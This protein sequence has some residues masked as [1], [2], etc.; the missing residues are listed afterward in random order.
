MK[1]VERVEAVIPELIPTQEY[2]EAL[3]MQV[4]I[5]GLCE[6]IARQLQTVKTAWESAFSFSGT[7]GYIRTAAYFEKKLSDCLLV[8][9]LNLGKLK[10]AFYDVAAPIAAAVIPWLNTAV[11]ALTDFLSVVSQVVRALTGG[12]FYT[13]SFAESSKNAQTAQKGMAKAVT[14]TGKSIRR[15]LAGFDEL[16]RLN[17]GSGGSGASFVPEELPRQTQSLGQS[18]QWLAEKLRWLVSLLAAID[19]TPA[20][21]AFQKL[22]A[23]VEPLT[24]EL[25]AGLEWAYVNLFVPLARWTVE[26]LLPAF[27]TTLAS[28][29][30]AVNGVLVALKPLGD[31]LWVNFLQPLGQWA[32]EKIIQALTW[33]REKLDAVSRWIGEN[34]QLVQTIGVVV[35][36]V[37]AAVTLLNIALGGFNGLGGT[38]AGTV[39]LFSGALQ[40]LSSPMGMAVLAI[41]ALS[42]AIVILI[43]NWDKVKTKATAA[44]E[45]IRDIWG[46]VSQW[47]RDTLLLPLQGGFRIMANGIIGYLNGMLRGGVKAVNALV[48]AMNSISFTFPDWVPGFGGKHFG[49]SLRTV[50]CPQIPYLARGAVLPANKPFLAVVGDQT[51]GTNVEAPL[52]TIQQAVAQVMDSQTDAIL[53]GFQASVGVQR[54]ILEALLGIRIGDEEI[55]LAA[56]RYSQGRSIIWGGGL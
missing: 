35:L 43:A 55:A 14:A 8:L 2:E 48:Q 32:G 44:W 23:A 51:H 18:L 6:K 25:F 12:I 24:R 5:V 13:D 36:A 16:E 31:W 7:A 21:T 10:A 49:F 29:L 20:Q 52:A 54:Q 37:V 15:S 46:G 33:L 3:R 42:A 45:S 4:V 47:F 56:E 28:A 17:G 38:A 53:A 9:R 19:T 1:Q 40:M 50:A 39:N 41:A 30:G 34:Q 26:D 11:R 22:C 27:L